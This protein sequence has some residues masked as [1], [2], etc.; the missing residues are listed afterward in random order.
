MAGALTRREVIVAYTSALALVKGFGGY[1]PMDEQPVRKVVVVEDETLRQLKAVWSRTGYSEI[2]FNEYYDKLST[3]MIPL[4]YSA[5]D[6]ERFSIALAEFQEGRNFQDN[7]GVFLSALIN[8][9]KDDTFVVHTAQFVE[10]IC[11]LGYRNMKNIVVDGAVGNQAGTVMSDGTITVQGNA[12]EHVGSGMTGGTI[13]VEGNAGDF[14]GWYMENGVIRI[15]G[16]SG[17][18]VCCGMEGGVFHVR[19]DY[20]RIADDIKHGKIY[21]KGRLIVDK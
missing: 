4:S 2:I 21:H 20:E 8:N 10:P 3:V 12:G 11:F 15:G 14:A 1:K 17:D 9:C 19:G 16:N 5:S 18:M 6:V 7:A 13:I